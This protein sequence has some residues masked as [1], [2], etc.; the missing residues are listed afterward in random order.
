MLK[1]S[2]LADYGV[3]LMIEVA[4]EDPDRWHTAKELAERSG[5]PAPTVSKVL[6]LLEK[7]DVLT[8]RRG[9]GSPSW[10]T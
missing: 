4:R 7:G 10:S 1:L 5:L 8:S 9:N 2:R 3:V 6:K